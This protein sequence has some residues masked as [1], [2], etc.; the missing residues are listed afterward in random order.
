[1]LSLEFTNDLVYDVEEN[2]KI[3]L[4]FCHL[5][6]L[7]NIKQEQIHLI[8]IN[9][10]IPN[11]IIEK[12]KNIFQTNIEYIESNRYKL[13]YTNSVKR[14]VKEFRHYE[15]FFLSNIF[16]LKNSKNF[17]EK[18]FLE[19]WS[20]LNYSDYDFAIYINYNSNTFYHLN[21]PCKDNKKKISNIELFEIDFELDKKEIEIF[22]CVKLKAIEIIYD[23]NNNKILE[24]KV[25]GYFHLVQY[26]DLMFQKYYYEKINRVKEKFDK[27]IIS[28]QKKTNIN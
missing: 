6:D 8:F 21:V 14:I 22:E 10:I 7:K 20:G 15:K 18:T 11:D 23:E 13:N 1:M 28:L 2:M 5:F 4:I 9:D 12:W 24:N 27:I 3:S 19:N 17:H 26:N 16:I 25:K